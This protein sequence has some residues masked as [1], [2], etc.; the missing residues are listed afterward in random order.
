MKKWYKYASQINNLY[1]SLGRNKSD[2][3]L[4]CNL[5]NNC[6]SRLDLH[7]YHHR[8]DNF[9]SSHHKAPQ[10]DNVHSSESTQVNECKHHDCEQLWTMYQINLW[11]VGLTFHFQFLDIQNYEFMLLILEIFCL[12]KWQIWLIRQLLNCGLLQS[13]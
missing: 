9:T 11:Y 5:V 12:F 2:D 13:F 10:M 1:C 8:L 3:H 6:W 4:N 7:L